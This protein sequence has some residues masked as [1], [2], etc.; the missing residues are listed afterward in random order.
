MS[1][2]EKYLKYKKKYLQIGAQFRSYEPCNNFEFYEVPEYINLYLDYI[3]DNNVI[4]IVNKLYEKINS[5]SPEE[6]VTKQVYENSL[7]SKKIYCFKHLNVYPSI[8]IYK[9]KGETRIGRYQF[10]TTDHTYDTYNYDNLYRYGYDNKLVLEQKKNETFV[11]DDYFYDIFTDEESQIL[12]KALCE[13]FN[14]LRRQRDASI[15]A[16]TDIYRPSS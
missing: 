3:N 8:F 12:I 1:Y 5:F 9:N 4:E 11:I 13:Y 15:K 2:L 10:A 14:K 6:L 7:K 16:S